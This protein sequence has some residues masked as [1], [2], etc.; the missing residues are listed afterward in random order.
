VAETAACRIDKCKR[1]YRAKG[2][3]NVHYREWR[4]GKLGKPRYKICTKEECRTR[5][6]KGSLCETH[7]NEW[8]AAR[9]RGSASKQAEAP[10]EAA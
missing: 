9:G 10:T 3:C 8:L 2:L 5:R 7:H 4:Q 1:P 6:F